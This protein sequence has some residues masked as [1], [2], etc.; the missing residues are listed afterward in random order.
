MIDL[1]KTKIPDLKI[2]KKGQSYKIF[3]V[4]G[5]AGEVMPQHLSTKEAVVIVQEGK[6]IL[7]INNENIHLNQNDVFIIPASVIHSM[8]IIE[9]FKSI[10]IMEHTSEIQFAAP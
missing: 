6:S 5:Y 8:L 3:E 1:A 9:K 10:V 2:L 7:M 4:T